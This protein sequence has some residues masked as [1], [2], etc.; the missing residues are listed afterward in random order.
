[1]I[2]FFF[3]TIGFFFIRKRPKNGTA[4]DDPTMETIT[5]TEQIKEYAKHLSDGDD[6]LES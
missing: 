2:F 1:M 5:K 3:D 4:V 6:E